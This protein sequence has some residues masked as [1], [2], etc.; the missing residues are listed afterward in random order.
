VTSPYTPAFPWHRQLSPARGRLRAT[1]LGLSA[2]IFGL[3]QNRRP[4]QGGEPSAPINAL[5]SVPL[6]DL[7]LL[8]LAHCGTI[9]RYRRFK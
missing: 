7:I 9:P 1:N 4:L 5:A 2:S 3:L 8:I 6:G